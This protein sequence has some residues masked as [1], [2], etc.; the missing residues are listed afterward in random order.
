MSTVPPEGTPDP[1]SEPAYPDPTAAPSTPPAYGQPA[2]PGYAQPGSQQPAYGQP[3]Y[4]APAPLT[5][6]DERLWATLSHVGGIVFGFLAPLVIWLVFRER[7]RFVE[8]QGKEALNFQ[9]LVTI[10]YV[11]GSITTVLLIGFVILPL[12]WIAAV[13]F[14]I[15]GAIAANRGDLYRYPFNWRI[16]K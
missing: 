3:A 10:A 6:S 13:V 2:A 16:I 15:M 4:A 8:D 12:A 9:I 11:V 14:G 7:S 1:A 5:Q